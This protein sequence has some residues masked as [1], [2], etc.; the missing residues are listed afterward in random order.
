MNRKYDTARFLEATELLREY[1]PN[2]GMTADLIVGF[3]G[4]TEENHSE[5]LAFI[6]KC[7]FSAMHVFPF[8]KRPGTKAA[9]MEGQ[10]T[11]AVKARRVA[12]AQKAASEMEDAYLRSCVGK[13]LSVLFETE[14]DGES[15]G[16]ASNYAHVYV[17]N[18]QLHGIVKNV[19]IDGVQDKML[20]GICV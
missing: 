15:T 1:F 10:L 17:H 18:E 4:E 9:E 6:K 16:H 19:K 14:R 11:N 12:E 8:S 5:T 20:V 3:P 13:S 2:C 7:S